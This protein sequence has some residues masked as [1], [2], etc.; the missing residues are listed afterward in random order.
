MLHRAPGWE[1]RYDPAG[2]GHAGP[3]REGSG[4][5]AAVSRKQVR[6]RQGADRHR[7]ESASRDQS[8]VVTLSPADEVI[9]VSL[10]MR[11]LLA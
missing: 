7:N 9:R 2:W 1:A 5:G 4:A 10:E 8:Q 11:R 6:R 3:G